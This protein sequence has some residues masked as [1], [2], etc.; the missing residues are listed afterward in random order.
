M[1]LDSIKQIGPPKISY[2][3]C[4]LSV[5]CC[6]DVGLSLRIGS[7]LGYECCCLTRRIRCRLG[8][9]RCLCISS[10]LGYSCCSLSVR[11]RLSVKGSDSGS[12]LGVG[13]CL[14]VGSLL[15]NGCCCCSL[16]LRCRL[17]I[18]CCLHI[19]SLLGYSC[20]SLSTRCRLGVDSDLGCASAK[21]IVDK[22]ADAKIAAAFDAVE[23]D[24][25]CVGLL[26][27]DC[28]CLCVCCRLGVGGPLC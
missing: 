28:C 25:L 27:H 4:R 9:G 26:G 21:A 13:R 22:Q 2:N 11:C 24:C 16:C 5:R 1:A 10:L 6:L 7:P 8:V 14:C 3:C 12:D 15:G 23:V 18:G 17:G 20:C 19:S